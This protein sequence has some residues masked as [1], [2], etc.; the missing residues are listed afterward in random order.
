[1]KTLNV[2][3]IARVCHEVNR[4]Y[5]Q[6]LSDHSQVPWEEAPDWQKES[7]ILGVRLHSLTPEVGPAAGHE[8]W[9]LQK[10]ADGWRYGET[11]DPETKTHPCLVPFDSLPPAQRAKDFIFQAL[12]RALLLL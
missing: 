5:C 3:Q 10:L 9:I 7:A 12:V 6:A 4:A 8:N 11:K 2:E 1:M